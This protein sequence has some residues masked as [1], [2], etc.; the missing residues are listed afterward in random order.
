MKTAKKILV[1]CLSSVAWLTLVFLLGVVQLS[2]EIA[3]NRRL[4]ERAVNA[5]VENIAKLEPRTLTAQAVT[6]AAVAPAAVQVLG[7]NPFQFR[8]TAMTFW[9]E[10]MIYEYSSWA[11]ERGVRHYP[12]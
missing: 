3:A 7:T 8:I 1:V 2:R 6:N 5:T 10:V 12:F 11:P 4:A 9:P